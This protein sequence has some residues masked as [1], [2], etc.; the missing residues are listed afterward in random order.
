M[1]LSTQICQSVCVCVCIKCKSVQT[2]ARCK[3]TYSYNVSKSKK[4]DYPYKLCIPWN[5]KKHTKTSKRH[6]IMN[7]ICTPQHKHTIM[8]KKKKTHKHVE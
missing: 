5:P 2:R 7:M 6:F 4:H 3:N 8:K 1:A